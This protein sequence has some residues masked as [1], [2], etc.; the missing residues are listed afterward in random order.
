[1]RHLRRHAYAF[2]KRGVGMYGLANIHRI[3]SGSAL[4]GHHFFASVFCFL[5]YSQSKN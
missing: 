4:E 1:M 3:R 2:A 5:S